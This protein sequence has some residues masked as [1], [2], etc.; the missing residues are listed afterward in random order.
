[1]ETLWKLPA[2]RPYFWN[3][4][5]TSV[6]E[7][8]NVFKFP[9]KT[10]EFTA[11]GS[12]EFVWFDNLDIFIMDND[13]CWAV[14]TARRPF[15]ISWRPLLWSIDDNACDVSSRWSNTPLFFFLSISL[16]VFCSTWIFVTT[17]VYLQKR[18]E[19]I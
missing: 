6:F 3:I 17:K 4:R 12:C 15:S 9:T 10:R 11:C 18:K 2:K 16:S 13:L 19:N 14:F 8:W 5:S 7:H 1:M